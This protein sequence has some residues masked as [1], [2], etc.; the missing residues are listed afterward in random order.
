MPRRWAVLGVV[1]AGAFLAFLDVTIVNIAFPAIE[2]DLGGAGLAGLSW[3]L[4]GYAIV[5]AALL[6]PAGR[7]A[8]RIGRRR[9]FV[10]GLSVFV[11]GSALCAIAPGVEALV[12]ARVVQ[13]A[14]AALMVPTSLALLLPEFPPT[15]RATAV[16]LWGATGAV[17]AATGPTLG[18]LL[19]EQAGWRWVFLVNLPL[20]ILT[21]VL[22]YRILRET[23]DPSTARPDVLGAAGLAAG[24]GALALG[25]VQGD[26]W[27]WTSPA[28]LGA[29]A[30][31]AA[32]AA[33]TVLRAR[34]HPQPVIDPALVRVRSF[35]VGSA[36]TLLFAVGFFALILGN[37]LFLTSVWGYSALEA[38]VA[39]TPGP[40]MAALLAGP[41]G[42][43]SDRYGQRV[44][45]VPGCLLFAAGCAFF[46]TQAGP[47]PDYAAEI[48]P[49][50]ILTGAGIGLAFPTLG[51]AAVAQLP[52]ARFATGS[53][54]VAMSRQI[55]AVLG[56]SLLVV[57][58][59]TPSPADPMPAFDGAWTLM[60]VAALAAGAATLGLG[61]V[62][63]GA[64]VPEG[65]PA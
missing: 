8:D 28:V 37:V 50:Q 19:V 23:R 64:P 26:D 54:V 39:I 27:G 32:L 18:G 36:A 31:A 15:Q 33:V 12:G 43:L 60:L 63:V 3:I 53:A 62:R 47:V 44:V 13:A 65:S 11:A 58:L 55:G 30:V 24:V 41:A 10:V 48:L 38:G 61:R 1:A 35:S 52:A 34:S 25:L 4:N 42:A 29:F 45:A 22:A 51:S 59:G 56:V 2:A 14:G 40:V 49:G 17:A 6:V 7:L 9:G 5:F 46:L 20:G 21:V 16:G 57:V